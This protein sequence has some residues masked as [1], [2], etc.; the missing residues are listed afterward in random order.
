MNLIR[1]ESIDS[2]VSTVVGERGWGRFWSPFI[3][4]RVRKGNLGA[5][6]VAALKVTPWSQT[7]WSAFVSECWTWNL[8]GS[9]SIKL[10]ARLTRFPAIARAFNPLTCS[11]LIDAWLLTFI[12]IYSICMKH[13]GSYLSRMWKGSLVRGERIGT[14]F[15]IRERCNWHWHK[16]L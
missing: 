3:Q 8:N 1:E 7:S 10:S 12:Q 9:N 6:Q 5:G 14:L 15:W 11:C 16:S 4:G 13:V 2:R